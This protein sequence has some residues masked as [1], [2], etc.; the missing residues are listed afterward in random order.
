MSVI[1]NLVDNRIVNRSGQWTIVGEPAFHFLV[2]LTLVFYLIQ[3]ANEAVAIIMRF[4][5]TVKTE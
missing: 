2:R 3:L 5:L 4:C 1:R